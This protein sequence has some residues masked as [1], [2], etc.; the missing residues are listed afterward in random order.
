[1]KKG[2][3]IDDGFVFRYRRRCPLQLSVQGAVATPSYPLCMPYVLSIGSALWIV[4]TAKLLCQVYY[5]RYQISVA[6]VEFH[7]GF[8]H[9]W[10]A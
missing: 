9:A 10:V 3:V 7:V 4:R 8:D 5:Q 2:F 6:L 1:M